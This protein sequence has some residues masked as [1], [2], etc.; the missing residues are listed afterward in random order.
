MAY[1]G[2]SFSTND[3]GGDR[4][5][6]CFWAGAVEIPG[7]ALCYFLMRKI[8]GRIAYVGMTAISTVFFLAV[9]LLEPGML[10]IT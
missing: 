10:S 8:G 9:P 5:S 3:L 2:L 1:Y 6:N 4:F 7:T